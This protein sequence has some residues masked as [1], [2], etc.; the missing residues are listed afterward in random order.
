MVC[1][2]LKWTNKGS[3]GLASPESFPE[4]WTGELGAGNTGE[5]LGKW[6]QYAPDHAEGLGTQDAVPAWSWRDCGE[7]R[8][9]PEPGRRGVEHFNLEESARSP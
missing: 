9:E 8:K 7:A 4:E 3:H 1:L 2:F 6:I 5:I